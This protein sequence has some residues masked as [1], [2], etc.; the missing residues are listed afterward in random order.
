MI[1]GFDCALL[2]PY[3]SGAVILFFFLSGLL[4]GSGSAL[5]LIEW[6]HSFWLLGD[7]SAK[8]AIVL[9]SLCSILPYLFLSSLQQNL[10]L[11]LITFLLV[12]SCLVTLYCGEKHF[13]AGEEVRC[14]DSLTAGSADRLTI[15]SAVRSEGAALFCIAILALMQRMADVAISSSASQGSIVVLSQISCVCAAV[16]LSVVWL[17]LKKSPAVSHVYL[18]LV[19]VVETLLILWAFVP[20]IQPI[21]VVIVKMAFMLISMV[22]M[23]ECVRKAGVDNVRLVG[24]YALCAFV[25]YGMLECGRAVGGAIRYF[26]AQEIFLTSMIFILIYLLSIVVVIVA[27]YQIWQRNKAF[28]PMAAKS[29]APETISEKCSKLSRVYRLTERE[30]Q[31]FEYMA[32]GRSA[33]YIAGELY[34]SEN[35]VRTYQKSLYKKLGIHTKQE[36]IDLAVCNKE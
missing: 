21:A 11:L 1:S 3:L 9:A 35:T 27:R 31:I 5:M 29:K 12:P 2:A 20:S 24:M 14:A 28:D 25:L 26:A 19:P 10:L 13:V 7:F 6:E 18:A 8:I 32:H 30:S 36:L 33:R 16:A 22:I 17:V 34:I 15:I 4:V 23:A